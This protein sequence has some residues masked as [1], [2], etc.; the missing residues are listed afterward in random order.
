MRS[1]FTGIRQQFL[2]RCFYEVNHDI[3]NTTLLAGLGRSG[4]TWLSDLL[5]YRNE[6]RYIF[7]PFHSWMVESA[8]PLI[9]NWYLRPESASGPIQELL[10]SILA[11]QVRTAWTDRLNRRFICKRRL[12]KTIRANLWLRWIYINY[13]A[14]PIILIIRHPI[15]VAA[16]RMR[17]KDG[18]E[19]KPEPSELLRQ[20]ELFDDFLHLYENIISGTNDIFEQ[21]ILSWCIAHHVPLSQFGPGEIRIVFYENLYSNPEFELKRIFEYLSKNWD[22]EIT[23]LVTQPSK[24]SRPITNAAENPVN[25]WTQLIEKSQIRKAREIISS[26]QLDHLYGGDLVP[27]AKTES[28]YFL[29]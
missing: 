4:T 18:W 11:G 25:N 7:E 14:I 13:P 28:E 9:G 21:H 10:L 16:S 17:L 26:F 6:Y 19:W 2:Q 20:K 27:K 15:A 5:N 1:R 3:R 29:G 23:N 12:I 8:Q 24:L 22:S